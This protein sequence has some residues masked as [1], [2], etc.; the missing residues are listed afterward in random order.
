[1]SRGTWD[2]ELCL[3]GWDA[4][5]QVEEVPKQRNSRCKGPV[6]GGRVMNGAEA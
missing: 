1:M 4:V 2:A 3:E 6:S 5:G